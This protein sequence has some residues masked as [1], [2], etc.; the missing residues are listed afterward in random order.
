MNAT[1]SGCR[2]LNRY[3]TPLKY[4]SLYPTP[5]RGQARQ[6]VDIAI[7]VSLIIRHRIGADQ[8]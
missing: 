8:D 4:P 5:N 6:A 2:T 7:E 1:D 3:Y